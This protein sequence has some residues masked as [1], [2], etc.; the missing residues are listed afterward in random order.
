MNP[1]L[2]LTSGLLIGLGIVLAAQISGPAGVIVGVSA[3]WLGLLLAW[4]TVE[5]ID[6]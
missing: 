6:P 1:I 5:V 4:T 3:V 2:P